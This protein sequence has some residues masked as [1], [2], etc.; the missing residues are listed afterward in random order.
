MSLSLH[1]LPIDIIYRIFD[2]LSEKE[3]FLST[4]HVNQKFN[5]ILN[6]YKRFQVNSTNTHTSTSI[7]SLTWFSTQTLTTLGLEYNQIE[8]ADA[9]A[10][11][12][13]LETNQ[14]RHT[15][16]SFSLVSSVL[17]IY[18]RY[19]SHSVWTITKSDL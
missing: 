9:Q 18:Y 16:L 17:C 19:S 7:N 15:H 14:V 12:Q 5:A 6:S 2:H 1:T 3:L 13:A 4:S 10:L 8:D 11:G